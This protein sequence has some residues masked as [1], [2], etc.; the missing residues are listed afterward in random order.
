LDLTIPN[1]TVADEIYTEN[2]RH[3]YKVNMKF[4]IFKPLIKL[5]MFW[6]SNHLNYIEISNLVST[7]I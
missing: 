7:I 5:L 4:A 2:G 1:G 3:V 6:E